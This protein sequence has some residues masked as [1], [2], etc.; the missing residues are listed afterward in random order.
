MNRSK[1]DTPLKRGERKL[2]SHEKK[3]KNCEVKKRK[4]ILTKSKSIKAKAKAKTKTN[5]N[6]TIIPTKNK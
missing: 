5:T 2:L 3:R 6:T 4:I 1:C